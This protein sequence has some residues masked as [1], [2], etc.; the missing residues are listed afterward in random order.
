MTQ[1]FFCYLFVSF[2]VVGQ[3][4]VLMQTLT[5]ESTSNMDKPFAKTAR[6]TR[7]ADFNPGFESNF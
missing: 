6:E 3:K 2:R 7:G 4:K 5:V 1:Y